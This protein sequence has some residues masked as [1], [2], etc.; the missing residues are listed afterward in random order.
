MKQQWKWFAPQMLGVAVLWS[1]C[2]GAQEIQPC[3]EPTVLEAEV[4]DLDVA[5]ADPTSDETLILDGTPDIPDALRSRVN[6]YLNVRS[7]SLS[8]LS[9]AGDRVLVTTR[10][11]ETYQLHGIDVPMGYREQLTFFDEPISGAWFRPGENDQ[12]VYRMDAGGTEAYQLFHLDRATGVTRALTDGGRSGGALFSNA[13]DQIAYSFNDLV[14]QD[15]HV[16]IMNPDDPSSA[17]VIAPME[18]YWYPLDFSPSDDQ[19]LVGRYI[20]STESEIWLVDLEDVTT[21]TRVTPEAPGSYPFAVFADD[22]T[23]LLA[24]DEGSEFDNLY[25]VPLDG[26]DRVQLNAEIPWNVEDVAVAP[27]GE[28]VAF[29]MNEG[30]FSRVYVYDIGDGEAEPISALPDGIV[31]G[32]QFAA[33][34]PVLGFTF[35][36]ATSPGDVYTYNLEDEDLTRWTQSEVGGLNP[37]GFVSPELVDFESFDGLRVPAYLYQ[38]EGDGPFPVV[39]SIHGGPESQARPYFSSTIQYLVSEMGVAVL[40]PNVRGS[41][42]YGRTYL[43]LDNG[44]LREDSVR[45]IGAA[46]DWIDTQDALD[47]ERVGVL[48]GSYGGYMVLASLM[49][50]SDRIVA[51]VDVV[52]I[53]NFV[54]FLENTRDYRRDLRRVEY[55]DERDP[56]MREFLLSISP[57]ENVDRIQS[58]LFVAQGANDPRVPASEAEQI[59]DAVRAAGRD[60]WYMLA[61]NEGHGFAKK[62]NRDTYT[63]LTLMFFAEHFGIAN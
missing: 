45:D 63:L 33:D 19:L 18:G 3:P 9:D 58:A 11:A 15:T 46:L 10:F 36:S 22:E 37:E 57:T 23:I 40:V 26:G 35:N 13:G 38:P 39:V 21:A 6:Q 27:D 29:A 32:M 62:E 7:A 25:L 48:G 5:D 47:S 59:V 43:T 34:A 24:T 20:S 4:E 51:G 31:Y 52:G 30:G 28:T 41:D 17:H 1:G 50:Y 49:H 12:V 54:T 53:S 16:W 55:G 42:G 8:S 2:G 61:M 56:E 60:V 14:E 44:M